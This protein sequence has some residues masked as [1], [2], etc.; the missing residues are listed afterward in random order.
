MAMQRFDCRTA[1]QA[2]RGSMQDG[3]GKRE[4]GPDRADKTNPNLS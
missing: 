2:L 3:A 1:G 4:I